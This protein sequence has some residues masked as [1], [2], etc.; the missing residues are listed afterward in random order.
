VNAQAGKK[1]ST[2][3][4]ASLISQAHNIEAAIGC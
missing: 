3:V 1:I 2:H 4:A